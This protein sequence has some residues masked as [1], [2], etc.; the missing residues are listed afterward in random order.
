[1]PKSFI[2]QNEAIKFLLKSLDTIH[3]N[4]YVIHVD[5]P[6]P[7][8]PAS[9]KEIRLHIYSLAM[10]TWSNDDMVDI[11]KYINTKQFTIASADSKDRLY[12]VIKDRLNSKI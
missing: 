8:H 3:S 11:R 7:N 2:G 9:I 10:L 5:Y 6:P 4:K 1:M 12:H